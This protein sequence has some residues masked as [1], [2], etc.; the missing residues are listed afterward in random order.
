MA[1]L[2]NSASPA[3]SLMGWAV[4]LQTR[5]SESSS[6]QE[7]AEKST[8]AA[9][10]ESIY[11]G[12]G[13]KPAAQVEFTQEEIESYFAL[14]TISWEPQEGYLVSRGDGDTDDSDQEGTIWVGIRRFVRPQELAATPNDIE[15]FLWDRSAAIAEDLR[16]RTT[17][18]DC[19][20]VQS[21]QVLAMNF[22][23]HHKTPSDADVWFADYIVTVTTNKQ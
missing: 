2:F 19:L 9:A 15:C 20:D 7:I 3:S 18:T 1:D 21:V 17:N 11:L 12:R 5:L 6:F 23:G 10:L 8:A 16:V 4:K 22:A 13:P 14:A